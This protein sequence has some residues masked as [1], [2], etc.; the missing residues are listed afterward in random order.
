MSL[1]PHSL[2]P[3]L[4]TETAIRAADAAKSEAL[5]ALRR[6][7]LH[8]PGLHFLE[9][10]PLFRHPSLTLLSEEEMQ[11]Q[12][13]VV[14]GAVEEV[15]LVP[16]EQLL[17]DCDLL[18]VYFCAQSGGEEAHELTG[19]LAEI[20]VSLLAEGKRVEV[21]FVSSD[22]DSGLFEEHFEAMPWLAVQYDQRD[23]KRQLA[24]LFGV[25][26][27][28]WL[29]WV[30][31]LTGEVLPAEGAETVAV[32]AAFF[33][34]SQELMAEGRKCLEAQVLSARQQE[35][36][37]R[38]EVEAMQQHWRDRGHVVLKS[39][40]H[41]AEVDELYYVSFADFATMIGDVKL[42]AG[43]GKKYYYE[44]EVVSIEQFAQLGW[45]TEGFEV[46]LVFCFC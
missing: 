39:H 7:Q 42:R 14:K 24:E 15:V 21:I 16:R 8:S 1:F 22:E 20:Y 2:L 11:Q 3:L 12:M 25:R 19:Q 32:G 26:R 37:E 23:K 34:W 18:G 17:Q 5:A 40:R 41:H 30:D 4:R 6:R 31:V 36:R 43:E 10:V 28:P 35:A 46:S 27:V 13:M 29:V 44:I 9:D 33:P 38:A 45:C